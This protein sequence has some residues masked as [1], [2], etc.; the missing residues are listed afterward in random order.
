MKE[1]NLEE[2]LYAA[3]INRFGK[4]MVKEIIKEFNSIPSYKRRGRSTGPSLAAATYRKL[5]EHGEPILMDE[6]ASF[7]VVRRGDVARAYRTFYR[8][9]ES[10]RIDTRKLIQR[11]TDRREAVDIY[12]KNKD[13]L[14]RHASEVAAATCLYLAGYANQREAAMKLRT[15][16][17][18]IRNVLRILEDRKRVPVS[19]RRKKPCLDC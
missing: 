2:I 8:G 18:S 5:V 6:V 1:G 19:D 4:D 15:T 10:V 16:E 3:L 11:Y 14:D 17:V 12:E 13:I 7:F 9:R